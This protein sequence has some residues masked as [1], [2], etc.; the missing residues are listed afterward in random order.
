MLQ[1]GTI[2]SNCDGLD[3]SVLRS[4]CVCASERKKMNLSWDSLTSYGTNLEQARATICSEREAYIVIKMSLTS[5]ADDSC[6]RATFL[7][8]HFLN[9]YYLLTI[10]SFS[11]H[12]FDSPLC[13]VWHFI[14]STCIFYINIAP[15]SKNLD[16]KASHIYFLNWQHTRT[17][18]R[19]RY[20]WSCLEDSSDTRLPPGLATCRSSCSKW[21]SE[22]ACVRPL[23]FLENRNSQ[24]CLLWVNKAT[25]QDS[26]SAA[27][28][29]FF[30]PMISVKRPKQ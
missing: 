17:E 28:R 29:L 14:Y 22:Q 3:V 13:L 30:L 4:S 1:H 7:R 6:K 16:W 10:V 25:L 15:C 9:C 8:K 20:F 27:R 19:W 24:A 5:G 2:I 26:Q 12:H 11:S 18:Q 23:S 21:V